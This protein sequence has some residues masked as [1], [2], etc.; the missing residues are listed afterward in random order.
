MTSSSRNRCTTH[1]GPMPTCE[2]KRRC[3]VRRLTPGEVG[4]LLG[5]HQATC[6]PPPARPGRASSAHE[7]VVARAPSPRS[8]AREHGRAVLGALAGQHL[9]GDRRS[10]TP[11]HAPAAG[12]SRPSSA[13]TSRAQERVEPGRAEA[14]R[15]RVPGALQPAAEHARVHAVHEQARLARDDLGAA[16]ARPVAARPPARA[17]RARPSGP[18]RSS[19]R[20][21]PGRR[22]ARRGRPRSAARRG[23]VAGSPPGRGSIGRARGEPRTRPPTALSPLSKPPASSPRRRLA[24]EPRGP[25]TRRTA[26]TE[27]QT[28][29]IAMV[30]L[31]CAEVAP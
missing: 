4:E 11:E 29:R 13:P 16:R 19:R 12:T 25:S 27:Q 2:W 21:R 1:L 17:A 20:A 23:S 10:S 15:H 28:A 26:V 9:L 31:D 5:P 30:T 24:G 7:R 8:H 14:R 18:T 3:S 22:R 6:R